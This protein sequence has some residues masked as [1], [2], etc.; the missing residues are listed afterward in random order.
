MTC[1]CMV[2]VQPELGPRRYCRSCRGRLARKG[3]EF[4]SDGRVK[5]VKRKRTAESNVR[6]VRAIER[7]FHV[8]LQKKDEFY[9]VELPKGH[10][11][12]KL[13]RTRRLLIQVKDLDA[14]VRIARRRS[15][16][17]TK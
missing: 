9:L 11:L 15:T 3:W 2:M 5:S 4:Y 14:W 17:R 12:A 1:Y 10:P 6:A 7:A 8:K 13:S 16:R